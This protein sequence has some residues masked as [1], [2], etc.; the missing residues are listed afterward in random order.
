MRLRNLVLAGTAL[1]ILAGTDV[2][3]QDQPQ[4]KGVVAVRQATMKANGDHMAAI[5]AILT[6]YPDALK[7]VAYHAAAIRDS[8]EFTPTLF[9]PGSDQPPTAALPPVWSD[10][11]GF[12]AAADKSEVLAQKLVDAA[13]G[14]DAQATMAAFATLGKEGCGGCHTTFRKKQS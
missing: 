9:P 14:G 6:E 4:A 10:Q 1:A 2:V 13:N 12:K 7:Q 3:A 5:K 8:A 11:A